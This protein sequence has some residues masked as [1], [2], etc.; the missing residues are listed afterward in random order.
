MPTYQTQVII[1]VDTGIGKDTVINNWHM[2]DNALSGPTI[3]QKISSWHT[4]LQT[5]Y[6]SVSSIFSLDIDHANVRMKTYDLDL[7]VPRLPLVN[8]IKAITAPPAGSLTLPH[9]ICVVLSFNSTFQS[10]VNPARRRGRVYLGPLNANIMQGSGG[11]A[12]VASSTLTTIANAATVL[13]NGG[14]TEGWDWR[15][16][17]EFS[18][19]NDIPSVVAGWVDNA[20]DVQRS[21]GVTATQRTNF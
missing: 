21:R 3:Q 6:N 1:P 7:P 16:R 12:R 11:D 20:F 13:K 5:F 4:A 15:T 2:N 14:T 19:A 9:E 17:S 10:G 8:E 18:D